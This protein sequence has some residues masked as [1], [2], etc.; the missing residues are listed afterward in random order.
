ML[1]HGYIERHYDKSYK[2]LGKPARYYLTT[3]SIKLLK[4]QEGVSEKVLHARYKD[5]SVSEDF[6]QRSLDI[7]KTALFIR[8]HYPDK[9]IIF[10]RYELAKYDYFPIPH[11]DLYVKKVNDD[12]LGPKA[13]FLEMVGNDHFFIT[14]KRINQYIDH[15]ET[16]EWPHQE[17][18]QV[19][20]IVQ[21]KGQKKRLREYIEDLVINGHMD[22]NEPE[23]KVID[24]LDMLT[25]RE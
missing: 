19:I 24:N 16:G 11:P 3:K 13:Y 10:T 17:Y 12:T 23:F 18:P 20:F 2:L 15:L 25:N 1:K 14:K 4:D 21:T 9:R 5:A 22:E 8:S 6:I 7:F